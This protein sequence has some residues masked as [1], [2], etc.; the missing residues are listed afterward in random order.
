MILLIIVQICTIVWDIPQRGQR[1]KVV[2]KYVASSRLGLG[3]S[4][5][6]KDVYGKYLISSLS[7]TKLIRSN[8]DWIDNKITANLADSAEL[9]SFLTRSHHSIPG[10]QELEVA[11]LDG[12]L[13]LLLQNNARSPESHPRIDA[14]SGVG[15]LTVSVPDCA[16][17]FSQN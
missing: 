12:I 7:L 10:D 5:E 1:L 6:D 11:T 14:H 4:T 8:A 2:V 15:T 16:N 17:P 3:L 9:F 13:I